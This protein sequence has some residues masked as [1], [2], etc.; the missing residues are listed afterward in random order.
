[1]YNIYLKER[2]CMNGIYLDLFGVVRF[3]VYDFIFI[4]WLVKLDIGFWILYIEFCSLNFEW[5]VRSK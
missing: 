1:M 3:C 4:I 2:V 5:V